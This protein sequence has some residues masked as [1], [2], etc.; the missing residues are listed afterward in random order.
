MLSSSQAFGVYYNEGRGAFYRH[1]VQGIWCK[2]GGLPS[3]T[4]EA[5]LVEHSKLDNGGI[6]HWRPSTI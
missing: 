1:M 3:L 4:M 5:W 6:H 2:V